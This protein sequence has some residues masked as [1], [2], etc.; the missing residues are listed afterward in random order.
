MIKKLKP[1]SEFA[2]NVLTLMTGTAIA[3]AIP[4]AVSPVL[5]RLYTPEDF[6]VF[7][8]FMAV[9][10]IVSVIAC[11]RYELAI[12]LPR[13]D[14]DAV[15]VAAVAFTFSVVICS[16]FLLFVCFF[17]DLISR[18]LNVG[19]FVISIMPLSVFLSGIYSIL[20]YM[21]N[22][23][24]LYKD[25]SEAKVYRSLVGGLV[26]ITG[27]V[28]KIGAAGL[29][30]GLIISQVVSNVKLFN[31]VN[32]LLK[33]LSKKVMRKVTVDYINFPKYSLWSGFLNTLSN[34]LIPIL[35][36]AFYSQKEAGAYFLVMRTLS[37]P[38]SFIGNSVSQVFLREF[39]QNLNQSKIK[40]SL[41]LLGVQRKLL[42]LSV[43]P[44]LFLFIFSKYLFPMVFG[45]NWKLSGL[46]ATYLIPWMFLVFIYSPI[47][48]TLDVIGKQKAGVCFQIMFVIS[49]FGTLYLGS[50][51]F[52]NFLD[53]IKLLGVINFFL[54]LVPLV[55]TNKQLQISLKD[56]LEFMFSPDFGRWSND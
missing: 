33:F 36:T 12:M 31:N 48:V 13:E 43:P 17:G 27:G 54:I 4:I 52:K 19:A 23:L 50:L 15:N 25:I 8:V 44:F 9:I 39:C 24:G 55:Y 34:Q 47:S 37:I 20:G 56:W 42:Y 38:L 26:Q 46:V 32:H 30:G 18:T 29:I 51:L 21:N 10:S 35:I 41:V 49:R 53:T 3:Q 40:A 1:K 6:G 45:E 11:G 14:E 7:A 16:L 5:T 22:R 28:L 2:K